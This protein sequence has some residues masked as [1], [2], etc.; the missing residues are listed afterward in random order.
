MVIQVL[1]VWS[2]SAGPLQPTDVQNQGLI[3][4]CACCRAEATTTLRH[5]HSEDRKR[6]KSSDAGAAAGFP[7]TAQSPAPRP[8]PTV[9]VRWSAMAHR[10]EGEEERGEGGQA[11]EALPG[12]GVSSRVVFLTVP[13][14][15]GGLPEAE[16]SQK[17]PVSGASKRGSS[18]RGVR[19]SWL[20]ACARPRGGQRTS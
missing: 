10:V 19:A 6:G 7:R 1:L 14:A 20:E 8:G 2:C 17:P 5:E 3:L 18:T 11:P 12:T 4:A 16:N 9:A 13:G 15:R